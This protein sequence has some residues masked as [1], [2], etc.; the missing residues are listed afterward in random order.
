LNVP[1]AYRPHGRLW[2]RRGSSL[3][4]PCGTMLGASSG[5]G[6][7]GVFASFLSRAHPDVALLIKINNIPSGGLAPRTGG[8]P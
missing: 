4:A 3:S 5:D 1:E 7:R 8:K 2:P 6:R